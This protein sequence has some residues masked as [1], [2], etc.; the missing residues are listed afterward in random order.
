MDVDLVGVR[1][2]R[3]ALGVD[4]VQRSA[5]TSLEERLGLVRR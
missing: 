2:L 1:S 4:E 3:Y 5:V